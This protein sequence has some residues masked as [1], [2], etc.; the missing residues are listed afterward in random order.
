[1]FWIFFLLESGLLPITACR[2]ECPAPMFYC[3]KIS[4]GWWTLLPATYSVLHVSYVISL[5]IS[6][7]QKTF[8]HVCLLYG[9]KHTELLFF[10]FASPPQKMLLLIVSLLIDF[11]TSF[12]SLQVLQPHQWA[13]LN[14]LLAKLCFVCRPKSAIFCLQEM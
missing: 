11:P 10:F 9:S 8:L 2:K 13:L 6:S 4:L 12:G 1:M 3:Q 5:C 14:T 7:V